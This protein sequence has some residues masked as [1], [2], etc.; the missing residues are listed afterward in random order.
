MTNY[1]YFRGNLY[2]GNKEWT[3]TQIT[4]VLAPR[5]KSKSATE[6]RRPKE[7]NVDV[8]VPPLTNS[9]FSVSADSGGASEFDWSITNARGYRSLK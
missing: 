4:V 3:I 9:D 2:N 7:Y 6:K 1:G 5:E 8:V